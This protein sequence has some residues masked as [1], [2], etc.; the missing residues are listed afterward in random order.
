LGFAGDH[1]HYAADKA[2]YE[3]GGGYH[4]TQD[5]WDQ[6]NAGHRWHDDNG[7]APTVPLTHSA[8]ETL[9]AHGGRPEMHDETFND[10]G[11]AFQYETV[12]DE[13]QAAVPPAESER[14]GGHAGGDAIDDANTEPAPPD[15]VAEVVAAEARHVGE[16]EGGGVGEGQ[17]QGQQVNGQDSDYGLSS[18][19]EDD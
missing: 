1:A 12:S 16:A 10:Y 15:A 9:T 14:S 6:F 18:S 11:H 7:G 13:G 17:K 3:E 4:Y 5:E 8:H 2:G 19:S